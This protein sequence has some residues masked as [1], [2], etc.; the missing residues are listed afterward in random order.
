MNQDL[1]DEALQVATRMAADR[2]IDIDQAELIRAL[3]AVAGEG[4]GQ[5][6]PDEIAEDALELL[7][8]ALGGSSSRRK[9]R[10]F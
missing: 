4:E 3:R 2:G 6:A 10:P 5:D 1:L 7:N 8:K 9:R